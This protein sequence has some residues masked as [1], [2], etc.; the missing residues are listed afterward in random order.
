MKIIYDYSIFYHQKLGGISRYFINIDNILKKNHE[1]K[2]L[3]PIHKNVFLKKYKNSTKLY[4]NDFPRFTSKL[5]KISNEII[6]QNY[7]NKNKPNIYHK[8]YYNSFWPKNYPG[9]KVIT[10]YD[11]IHEIFHNDFNLNKNLLP[12]KQILD[13]TD[14]IISISN[15]TK[16]DLINFFFF[17]TVNIY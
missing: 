13:Y 10:V 14:V 6:T 8:T 16:N 1:T 15:N 9:I 11:L 3:A 17:D 7:V 4:L 12:K 2:I 5:I